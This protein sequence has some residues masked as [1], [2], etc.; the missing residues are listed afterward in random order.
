MASAVS[1]GEMVAAVLADLVGRIEQRLPAAVEDEYD[2]V[3]RLRTSV[4][5]L[6]TALSVFGH[7][8]RGRP[9][10]ALRRDLGDLGALLGVPRD[11]EVRADLLDDLL[12]RL[13]LGDLRADLV[14]PLRL[15]HGG[16]HRTFAAWSGG[17]AA[18]DLRATLAEWSAG[19]PLK[20]PDKPAEEVASGL[21]LGQ[22][23]VTLGLVP[24]VLAEASPEALHELRKKAR[25]LRHTAE[26]V[27]KEPVAL[28]GADVVDLGAAGSA[29]QSRLGDHRD[30]LLL[31][32][33]VERTAPAMAPYSAVAATARELA[34]EALAGLPDDVERLAEARDRL[35]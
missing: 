25:R 33:H 5:R 2:G 14:D 3:H 30:A 20:R 13:E 31:A 9:T 26:A 19:P 27:T 11:L 18:A 21:V 1:T 17:A 4:R 16:A 23:D 12:E 24:D 29:I 7:H 6:R 15:E 22:A 34:C 32:E 8:L 10:K 35:R 28:L